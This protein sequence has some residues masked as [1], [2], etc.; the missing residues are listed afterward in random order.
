MYKNWYI[1]VITGFARVPLIEI[2]ISVFRKLSL[3]VNTRKE[4]MVS[5]ITPLIPSSH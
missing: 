1:L 2:T 3:T 5:I 4:I